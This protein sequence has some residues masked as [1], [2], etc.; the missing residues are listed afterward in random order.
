MDE[1]AVAEMNALEWR[2]LNSAFPNRVYS[3]LAGHLSDICRCLRFGRLPPV[4]DM[5]LEYQVGDAF[6]PLVISQAAVAYPAF[7]TPFKN[8]MWQD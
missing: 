8:K 3:G 2:E 7:L 6:A 4:E 5:H 1:F